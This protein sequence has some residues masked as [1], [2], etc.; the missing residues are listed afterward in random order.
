MPGVLSSVVDDQPILTAG[1]DPIRQPP[2]DQPAQ[3]NENPRVTALPQTQPGVAPAA[4]MPLP[5]SLNPTPAAPATPA[6][7]ASG[8]LSQAATPQTYTPG[9]NS[10]VSGQLNQLLNGDSPYLQRARA[11]ATELAN[12]RGLMNSSIAASAGEAA[13][14]DAAMPIAQA[15]AAA[16]LGAQRYGADANNT[17]AQQGNAFRFGQANQQYQGVLNAA[18]TQQQ[19]S[20][21]TQRDKAQF[22]QQIR[23]IRASTEADL[24]RMD[25]QNQTNLSGQYRQAA[26]STY[27]GYLASVTAIQQSDMDPDVKSQQ[28]A[29]LQSLFQTRQTFLNTIYRSAPQ[30]TSE[31]SQVALEFGGS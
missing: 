6:P 30:W 25:R 3:T 13:A 9:E 28:I 23:A 18:A 29:S 27:D 7:D 20:N 14:I 22:D 12:S 4:N 1:E 16:N 17:F 8:V 24:Q 26:Q 10:L 19:F 21:Q 15:D 31:W 11:R 2:I 5:T